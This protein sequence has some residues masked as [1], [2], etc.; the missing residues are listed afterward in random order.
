ML[1]G[2]A[3]SVLCSSVGWSSRYSASE[4]FN[5]RGGDRTRLSRP[6]VFEVDVDGGVMFSSF[7]LLR[8]MRSAGLSVVAAGGWGVGCR[9]LRLAH[10]GAHLYPICDGIAC[11]APPA[12]FWFIH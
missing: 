4:R 7:S 10:V 9:S 11:P 12:S 3:G 1:G 6:V 8:S 5:V 2:V